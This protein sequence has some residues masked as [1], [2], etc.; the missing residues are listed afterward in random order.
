MSGEVAT[1]LV[2]PPL[3]IQTLYDNDFQDRFQDEPAQFMFERLNRLLKDS[4]V[5]IV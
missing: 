5:I 4:D 1:N 3:S 2:H